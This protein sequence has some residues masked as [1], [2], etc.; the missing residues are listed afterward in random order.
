M[1]KYKNSALLI[2]LVIALQLTLL[3][4]LA[5]YFNILSFFYYSVPFLAMVLGM[6][7]LL[8]NTGFENT[9]AERQSP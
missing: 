3:N 2:F 4:I 8:N 9:G 6:K 7:Y 5:W 1:R